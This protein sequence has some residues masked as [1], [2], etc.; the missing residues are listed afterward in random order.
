MAL[1]TFGA[2]LAARAAERDSGPSFSNL[3]NDFCNSSRTP[4]GT[5]THICFVTTICDPFLT[6]FD[7]KCYK[8]LPHINY[9]LYGFDGN[10]G[11]EKLCF[12]YASCSGS[13][14]GPSRKAREKIDENH[15]Q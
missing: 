7:P 4:K 6:E 14:V 1:G 13:K 3:F 2:H 9:E 11:N 8:M 12:D 15:M 5:Q 10:A